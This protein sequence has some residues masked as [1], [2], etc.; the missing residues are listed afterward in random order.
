MEALR[1]QEAV[2]K[3][4]MVVA[5]QWARGITSITQQLELFSCPLNR[6]LRLALEKFANNFYN[7]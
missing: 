2:S 1:G 3:P 7:I 4:V 5:P 6:K